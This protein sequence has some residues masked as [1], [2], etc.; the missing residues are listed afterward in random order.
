MDRQR[1]GARGRSHAASLRKME[2]PPATPKEGRP[3]GA[4][5]YGCDLLIFETI[6]LLKWVGCMVEA[7]RNGRL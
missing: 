2:R 5:A 6:F 7:L 3:A 1:R 4:E